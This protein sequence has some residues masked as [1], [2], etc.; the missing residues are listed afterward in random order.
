MHFL[1]TAF[2]NKKKK[3]GHNI[4]SEAGNGYGAQEEK[5]EAHGENRWG[6][7]RRGRLT[8]KKGKQE[9]PETMFNQGKKTQNQGPQGKYMEREGE[10]GKDQQAV[11]VT[12]SKTV[13]ALLGV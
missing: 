2:N 4:T 5:P 8:R 6:E 3:K 1:G 11:D 12:K 9:T 7:K 10:Q 13:L